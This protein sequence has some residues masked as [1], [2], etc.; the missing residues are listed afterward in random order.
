LIVLRLIACLGLLTLAACGARA[1]AID[2]PDAGVA[3]DLS[4]PPLGP[5]GPCVSIGELT[6]EVDV[7][8][9]VD[10]S[11]SMQ[12]K[13]DALRTRIP[14]LIRALD[15]GPRERAFRSYHFGVVT[16]DL[17]APGL[18]CGAA[19]AGHLQALGAEAGANC[20]GPVGGA[21]YL[22]YDER[23]HTNNLPPGT[24]LDQQLSCMLAVGNSGCGFTMPLEAAYRA[25]RDDDGVNAGFLRPDAVLLVMFMTDEDDCSATSSEAFAS[26]VTDP[27]D[28]FRCVARGI[29]CD[30]DLVGERPPASYSSCRP[31]TAGEGSELVDV[32]KYI[33]LFRRPRAQGGS[34]TIHAAWC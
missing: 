25:L 2:E 34:R 33:E 17:G 15:Y 12:V 21:R 11:A 30:G 28:R 1:L 23:G 7:L 9:V 13:Q 4:L 19:R 18:S 14:D 32:Q 27:L 20:A 29:W 3:A 31:A 6:Y 22:E 24:P 8:F 16:T 5:A 26:Y 10:D